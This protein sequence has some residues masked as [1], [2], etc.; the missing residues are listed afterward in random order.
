MSYVGIDV[1]KE[2]LDVAVL[3]GSGEVSHFRVSH[4]VSGHK[5][6][7]AE[8][9]ADCQVVC[10]ATGSYHR[11]LQEALCAAGITLSV[12]NPRQA[13]GYAKSQNRRN[14][15]DIVDA[16]L[17]AQFGL[18]RRPAATFYAAVQQVARE[19][20]A[21]N[22]DLGRLRNRLEAAEQGLSHREVVNSLERRIGLPEKE[23]NSLKNSCKLSLKTASP[24]SSGFCR[25]SPASAYTAP[26]CFWL[27]W[28]MCSVSA[29]LAVW[30]PLQA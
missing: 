28:V 14:K 30:G 20:A 23:K 16:L 17:L 27:N 15:T 12:V 10:E 2:V 5:R 22:E 29:P 3:S 24:N 4:N 9:G 7:V 19:L 25:A 18:Q 1:S 21:L 11:K 6:L 26:P 8:L 13:L